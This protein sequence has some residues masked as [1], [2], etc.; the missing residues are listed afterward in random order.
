MHELYADLAIVV[1]DDPAPSSEK[2]RELVRYR[3]VARERELCTIGGYVA[4]HASERRRAISI[5]LRE[6]VKLKSWAFAQLVEGIA[7]PE[8]GHLFLCLNVS[9]ADHSR[10]TVKIL[11]CDPLNVAL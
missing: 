1:A 11:P 4:D 5:D 3:V 7:A 8:K 10:E 2:K 6:I 9:A